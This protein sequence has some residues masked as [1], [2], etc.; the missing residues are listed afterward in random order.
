MARD[1]VKKVEAVLE[2]YPV[3]IYSGQDDLIVDTPGTMMW[4]DNLKHKNK[5][6]F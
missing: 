1:T 5:E 4:V 2:K 6:K 3:L